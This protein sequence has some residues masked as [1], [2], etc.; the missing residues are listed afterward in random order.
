MRKR[1]TPFASVLPLLQHWRGGLWVRYSYPAL[2]VYLLLL[3]ISLPTQAQNTPTSAPIAVDVPVSDTITD[4][5]PFDVWEFSALPGEQY[6]ADMQAADG[7]APLLGLRAPSGDIIVASNQF[8]NGTTQDAEPDDLITIFFEIPAVG[9]YALVATRVGTDNGTTQGSYT[10]TMTMIAAAPEPD[11]AYVDVAF[12]C[13]TTKVTTAV[14]IQFHE[15][16]V[17]EGGYRI[18]VYGFDGFDPVIRLGGDDGSTGAP[19]ELARLLEEQFA[20]EFGIGERGDFTFAAA[21]ITGVARLDV[22]IEQSE[23]VRITVGSRDGA[24]G[25]FALHIDG[26][27]IEAAGDSDALTL[28]SGPFARDEAVTMWMLRDGLSRLDPILAAPEGIANCADLGL[29]SCSDGLTGAS[30]RVFSEGAVQ[31]SSDR[32]DAVVHFE[33]TGLEPI[34]LIAAS[35]NPRTTG[36]YMLWLFGMLPS[37]R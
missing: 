35:Q 18:T 9:D 3:S 36:A 5:A 14:V 28:R 32:L 20:F 10:L 33:T 19:C 6:R 7:L 1:L 29:R 37:A 15:Q 16:S 22:P 21:D 17:P 4:A 34:E 11:D 8:D 24:S 31:L 2:L 23:Q 25:R 13:S 27:T 30:V 26:F 12:R